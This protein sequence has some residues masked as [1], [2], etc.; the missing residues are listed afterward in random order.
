MNSIELIKSHISGIQPN[1]CYVLCILSRKKNNEGMADSQQIM[2]RRLIFSPSDV[3]SAYSE[4]KAEAEALNLDFYMYISVNPRSLK[5]ALNRYIKTLL[6]LNLQIDTDLTALRRFRK[7]SGEW[8]S[9]LESPSSRA[10][11]LFLLD[12]DVKDNLPFLLQILE[13]AQVKVHTINETRNGFHIITSPFDF[14]HYFK[15]FPI[16]ENGKKIV[17][18]KPDALLFVED[19]KVI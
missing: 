11:R 12:L 17:E 13:V 9:A 2:K 4:L 16:D 10:G 3:E 15:D 1:Q 19:L 7:L 8:Y 5:K 18:V 6:D 14:P